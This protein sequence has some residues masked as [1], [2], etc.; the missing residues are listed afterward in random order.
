MRVDM[1]RALLENDFVVFDEYTSVVD[2]NVAQVASL[3][4]SKAIKKTNK[5]FIAVTCHYDVVE[6]LQPDWVFDTDIMK[7]TFQSAHGGENG[8][9]FEPVGEMNGK[10]LGDIII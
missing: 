9:R 3:A 8:L 6:W 5:Q 7:T 4:I 10:H 1:A 2:R